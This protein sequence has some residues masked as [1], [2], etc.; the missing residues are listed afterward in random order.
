[1]TAGA[2][3]TDLGALAP[4]RRQAQA[5]DPAAVRAAAQEFE[6]LLLGELVG[7]MRGA[8]LAAGAMDGAHT[9]TYFDL[10]DRQIG[11]ELARAGGVGLADALAAALPGGAHASGRIE[12]SPAPP[13]R[14][15]FPVS[16]QT[17][18][19]APSAD[20]TG[21]A[22]SPDAQRF[23]TELWPHAQAAGQRLGVDGRVLLAQAALES[24]WGAHTPRRADGTPSHNLFGIKAGAGWDGAVAGAST[25]EYRGGAL[26]RERADFRAYDGHAQGFDDYARLIGSARYADA[27]GAGTDARA[28]LQALQRAGYATDPAYA[29]KVMSILNGPAF[30]A[31]LAQAGEGDGG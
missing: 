11:T 8:S 10:F 26:V 15:W 18:P 3:W 25:L 19:V 31:R 29:D 14:G 1:M 30:A 5:N 22:A 6:G 28:Y 16:R 12:R 7:R 4:L 17:V 20:V 21:A 13:T 27:H 24:G 9:A 23:I 2:A